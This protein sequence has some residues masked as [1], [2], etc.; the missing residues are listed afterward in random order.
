L[1][2]LLF[3]HLQPHFHVTGIDIGKGSR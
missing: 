3:H 2:M 1:P